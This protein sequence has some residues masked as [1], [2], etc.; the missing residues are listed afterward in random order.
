MHK[1]KRDNVCGKCTDHQINTLKWEAAQSSKTLVSYHNTTVSQP[2]PHIFTVEKTSNLTNSTPVSQ[3][4]GCSKK[5]WKL[6]K[7]SKDSMK[8]LVH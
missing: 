8:L 7:S 4:S 3:A 6:S 1:T 5:S 2:R